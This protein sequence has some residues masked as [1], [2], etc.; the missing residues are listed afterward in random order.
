M[1]DYRLNTGGT[2]GTTAMGGV[3]AGCTTYGNSGAGT[4]RAI[5][6]ATMAGKGLWYTKNEGVTWTQIT[7]TTGTP[8]GTSSN[9]G[10]SVLVQDIPRNR[11]YAI[12]RAQGAVWRM[13]VSATGTV[14]QATR[15]FVQP[16]T[17]YS[18][19]PDAVGFIDLDESTNRLWI[20]TL[21]GVYFIDSAST[22]P[23]SS[24]TGNAVAS[25]FTA[26]YPGELPG[27]LVYSPFHSAV[28]VATLGLTSAG[29]VNY[30]PVRNGADGPRF[31]EVSDATTPSSWATA[32]D[33]ADDYDRVY[34]L[35]YQAP[36]NIARNHDGSQIA[37]TAQGMGLGVWGSW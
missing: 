36:H 4:T 14:S 35:T 31:L 32:V 10:N 11:I 21:S 18:T 19:S 26:T 30:N 13:D 1:V 17:I 22:V 24:G 20:S 7:S 9:Y 3:M 16:W 8:F 2:V 34:R 27:A 28:M 5:V 15:I 12:D 37:V 33:W 23:T 6:V 25:G 29:N